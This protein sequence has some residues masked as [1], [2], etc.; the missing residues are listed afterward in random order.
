[1]RADVAEIAIHIR[2]LERERLISRACWHYNHRAA[3]RGDFYPFADE[4]CDQD[5]LDRISVNYLRHSLTAYEQQLSRF[6]GRVGQAEAYQ[7]IKQ[8]VLNAIGEA[9][10][11]LAAEC[12]RQKQDCTEVQP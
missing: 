3:D 10:P 2:R 12:Q 11:W 9:Y 4:R 6:F 1:M 5:F 7:E 8:K